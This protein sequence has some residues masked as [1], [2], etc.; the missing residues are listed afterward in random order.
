MLDRVVRASIRQTKLA[1]SATLPVAPSEH[2]QAIAECCNFVRWFLSSLCAKK[3]QVP[4]TARG[5]THR[6]TAA[7]TAVSVDD[8]RL[9]AVLGAVQCLVA[10][11]SFLHS[12]T[13]AT[14][15]FDPVRLDV[16]RRLAARHAALLRT[17][18]GQGATRPSPSPSPSPTPEEEHDERPPTP[19]PRLVSLF[20]VA[21][22]PRTN[23]LFAQRLDVRERF[24]DCLSLVD[25]A[26]D[27][28]LRLALQQPHCPS[29][30]ADDDGG[31]APLSSLSPS[32]V[33]R[34]GTQNLMKDLR[35]M[36]SERVAEAAM[37]LR[38]LGDY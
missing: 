37:F 30:C 16:L 21:C 6:P 20:D 35:R 3:G 23:L 18:R 32:V 22:D 27:G 14:K 28:N 2:T 29:S 15:P 26:G 36:K 11:A 19:P 25:R 12:K 4:A 38:A 5:L 34:D 33:E 17:S 13:A 9:G 8:S 24:A 7:A 10:Q 1:S 31:D